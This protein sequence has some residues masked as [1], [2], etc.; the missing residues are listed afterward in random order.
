VEISWSLPAGPLSGL[1]W[2]EEDAPTVLCVHGHREQCLVW[3]PLAEDLAT[4]G[5]RVLAPDLR[6]HGRSAHEEGV[7]GY[8]VGNTLRDL[9]QLLAQVGRVV[10]LGHSLGGMLSLVLASLRPAQL[11]GLVL[12]DVPLR[13]MRAASVGQRL[14]QVLSVQMPE[15]A[16]LSGVDEAAS[17]LRAANSD[18]AEPL[19]LQLAERVTESAEAGV[20]WRWDR[21][22][23]LPLGE[24]ELLS[25]AEGALAAL[26]DENLPTAA[27]FGSR[28]QH[29]RD[30]DVRLLREGGWTV[31]TVHSGHHPHLACPDLLADLVETVVVG[32]EQS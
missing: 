11:A 24:V 22:L 6:G 7:G 21:R 10:L 32:C 18:L 26:A 15:H 9:D 14:A 8:S 25:E 3:A 2:G 30:E 16:V 4:R 1:S 29:T 17:R 13:S 12:V 31:T 5:L 19:S 27:I 23:L 20:R 28:S